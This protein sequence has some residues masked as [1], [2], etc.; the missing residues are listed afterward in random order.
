MSSGNNNNKISDIDGTSLVTLPTLINCILPA[1]VNECDL[2]IC[3]N[4]VQCENF[5]G[6]YNC[7]CV[8]GWQGINCE[9]GLESVILT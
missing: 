6:G 9:E 5:D 4:D 8:T 3:Q 1:D 2:E 7:T